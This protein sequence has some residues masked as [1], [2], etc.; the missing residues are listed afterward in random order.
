[1]AAE[2]EKTSRATAAVALRDLMAGMA[3]T[4]AAAVAAE[5]G[6]RATAMAVAAVAARSTPLITKSIASGAEAL[7]G[8]VVAA[9]ATTWVVMVEASRALGLQV[10]ERCRV[11]VAVV[12]DR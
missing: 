8:V 12:A 2:Q 10:M 5:L 11:A 7:Q 1:M 4:M 9:L 3:L 6:L